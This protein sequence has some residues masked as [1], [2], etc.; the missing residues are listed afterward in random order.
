MSVRLDPAG[1]LYIVDQGKNVIRQV[2]AQSGIITTI[3]GTGAPGF[4]GDGGNATGAALKN[5]TGVAL[6]SAGNIYVADYANNVIRRIS[7]V[8]RHGFSEHAGG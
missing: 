4:F 2:N 7:K 1:N 6:D 8:K 5:P 3:A